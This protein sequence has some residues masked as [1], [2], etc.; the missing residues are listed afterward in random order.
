[1]KASISC[2]MIVKNES[3]YLEEC[4]K[5]IRPYVEE[6]VIVD[7]GS[8]DNTP[9][10][11]KKYADIF[12]IY[13]ECNDENGLIADFSKARQKSFDLATKKWI[14][15]ADADDKL[16]HAEKLFDIIKEH[17]KKQDNICI[18]FP[19][20]YSKDKFG[21][22][23]CRHY[24]ERLINNK[25]AYK[26]INRVH[27][28]LIPK[29]TKSPNIIYKS[30]DVV[31][32]HKR[33]IIK[34]PVEN[35]RNLRI[36]KKMY[37]DLGESDARHLYYLGLEYGNVGQ[38]EESIK[39]LERYLQL[40]GWDDE[41]Y[42]AILKLIDYA[43][44]FGNYEEVINLAFRAIRIKENWGE[45]YFALS[46]AHY[47]MAQK[48]NNTNDW[49][50]CINFGKI[51]LSLPRTETLLF[52][53]NAE[54]DLEIYRFINFALNKMGRIQEA[55]NCVN[56][57]LKF[58]PTD[59]DLLLNKKI[60]E[61]VLS[62]NKIAEGLSDLVRMGDLSEINREVI[63][64]VLNN[65]S[66]PVQIGGSDMDKVKKIAEN[67]DEN[68]NGKVNDT[69]WPAY[70][71][72][73][74]YPKNVKESDFPVAKIT[75]HSQAF[76][77]P[78]S[79]VYDDLPMRMT[80]QQ[81]QALVVALWKEY[82]LH[83]E[84]LS[85]ISLLKNAPYR[86][87]HTN[88]TETLL[89]KTIGFTTWIDNEAEYDK[90]N[91]TIDA[92][93][94]LLKSDMTPLT[95]ELGGGAYARYVWLTDRIPD[96]NK[97]LLDMACIDGQ[98]TNRWG[99]KGW[100]DVTGV[101]CCTNSIK[102]AN[103][104]AIEFN[105]GA[106]HVQCYFEDAPEA[107]NYE[108][109]DYI[110]CGDVYEHLID[111]VKD[112][113]AP[114]RKLIKEDGKMLMVTPH[115]AWFRGQ[116]KETAH[117]WLWANEG[118][119][120]LADKN[121][122]HL[123]APS[124]KS[125]AEHFKKAGWWIKDCTAVAQWYPD[126]PDQGNVC[127]EAWAN[128]PAIHENPKDIVFFIGD[129]LEDITPH[130]VDIHGNGG[131]EIA[132]IQMS[133][134]LAKLGHKVRMYIGC[135]KWGEGIYNGVEYYQTNKFHD[136]ECD[137][138]I[139][140]RY[141]EA[142]DKRLKIKSKSKILW[143]HDVVP[144][145]LTKELADE[146]NIIFALTNWHK[147]NI[148]SAY[149]FLDEDKVIVTQ[150]GLDLSRFDVE[151][152]RNPHKAV[153]SSSPDRYLPSLLQMWPKIREQVPDSTLHIFYGFENWKKVAINDPNQTRLINEL[154][155]K[156]EELKY[157]G[158]SYH[159]RLN[160]QDLAKEYKSAGVWTYSNWFQETSCQ[161]AGSLI[162]TKEGMKKI[163]DIKVGDLVLTHKGRFR[164]VTKLIKKEYSGKLYS[165]KKRKDFNP[166][167]LTEEHP[168]LTATF[169]KRSDSLGYHSRTD[170]KNLKIKW[171]NPKN[172]KENLN[173]LISPKMAF[174]KLSNLKFSDY[175]DLPVYK[176]G[177]IGPKIKRSH[178]K[179]IN[180]N[181]EIT[182]E[183]MYMMGLFA[184]EGC[185]TAKKGKRKPNHCTITFAMHI[186]EM[187]KAQ[188]VI[189]FFGCGKIKQ[190]SENGISITLHHSVW[191]K[192][193]AHQIGTGVNKRI[194]PFVWDC[195]KEMQHAFM[196]GMFE[197]DGCTFMTTTQNNGNKNYKMASYTSISP[198]LIYGI[199][200]LLAN[201]DIYS[202]IS[203]APNRRAYKLSWS[204]NS[205]CPQHKK[206]ENGF[207]TRINAIQKEDYEGLV[208][209]FNV[210]EDQSY[211]TD[212]TIV[213]N[214]IG[215]MEAQMAGLKIITSPIAALNETVADRGTMIQGDWL[216]KQYQDAFV[217]ATVDAML[218]TKEEERKSL[219]Q[220]AKKHFNWDDVAKS[221]DDIFQN[222]INDIF[223]KPYKPIMDRA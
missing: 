105:T 62:K 142:L 87:R 176:N 174:G 98:M 210:E 22:V 220:Y 133:K 117:P 131:S 10:I 2:C 179:Y 81:L 65:Q 103:E 3:I 126:V 203:Y 41:K 89:K 156:M 12:E 24:R 168:L 219:T 178:Y 204:V 72:P 183:F 45:A 120:W 115:G 71:R 74:G 15:W 27:E 52:V 44:F 36:L 162:F 88:E 213:H 8:S 185:C 58:G 186:K 159:G 80:D 141:A 31:F 130:I 106:K 123:V 111:P 93:G 144:K 114:A 145:G 19:Y 104:K 40:S 84:V 153:I 198:S 184:A 155:A 55:L 110:T 124:F 172:L 146:T 165:I 90:G 109:Y 218:N 140:S 21:N 95:M 70:H 139:V 171:E 57:A 16:E 150:N 163:E 212:R 154:M 83:D 206:I 170:N 182:S 69:E 135:G 34:K 195:S 180:D 86:I 151:V 158:V 129:G 169:H 67:F 107:L 60:Y 97:K 223:L 5:S 132:A 221:W 112:L 217:K 42:M 127:V 29:D 49:E 194:P 28:V 82:M 122:G 76:G 214:C 201:E 207:A 188:R 11:A 102:I 160:Q 147:S 73:E 121:R 134:R 215:A 152:E 148:L 1:M 164:P 23:V 208:Y 136:L 99:M 30:D 149:N 25:N 100:T 37:E 119:H 35:N 101:D 50:K 75:P 187:K 6:L 138:L 177:K 197:G 64:S 33:D 66:I 96:K 166:I 181:I 56:E 222:T 125:V 61:S 196:L 202:S 211:V 38:I 51:G 48:N 116:F 167:V 17:D 216:S 43:L 46:K 77:I 193:L 161:L 47:F 190:T 108:K 4:L 14:M 53:N 54:R 209:N 18:A 157:Q 78:E 7:T 199:S 143:V 59:E 85:A 79:F 113:L 94:N 137:V 191:S 91:S 13:T 32:D 39:L 175:I 68:Y 192:F 20:L 92:N 200:Q 189:D 128:P 63:F 9:E 205:K 118:N 173:Y 26:W